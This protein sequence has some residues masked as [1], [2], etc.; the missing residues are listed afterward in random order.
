MDEEVDQKLVSA[1]QKLDA[2][3]SEYYA[4]V[5]PD[6][7]ISAWALSAHKESISLSAENTTSVGLLVKTEQ[8]FP[9]TTGLLQHAL[10][11]ARGGMI[12]ER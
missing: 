3:V 1:K 9:M 6:V 11:I 10:D 4:T 7:Y 8:V 2:A 5:E 12:C